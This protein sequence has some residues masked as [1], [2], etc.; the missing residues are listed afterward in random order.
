MSVHLDR[1]LDP[2]A[3][4]ARPMR[5]TRPSRG[6]LVPVVVQGNPS[7]H[8]LRPASQSEKKRRPSSSP[9]GRPVGDEQVSPTLKLPSCPPLAAAATGPL[10]MRQLQHDNLRFRRPVAFVPTD[11][12]LWPAQLLH[13]LTETAKPIPGLSHTQQIERQPAPQMDRS[14]NHNK[15]PAQTIQNVLPDFGV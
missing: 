3:Q 15:L 4:A 2:A 13:L 9:A 14:C 7:G 12:P 5:Q 8:P 1:V 6:A 10:F 11:R